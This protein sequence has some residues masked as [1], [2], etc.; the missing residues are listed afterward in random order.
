MEVIFLLVAVVTTLLS[1]YML[2]RTLF[3]HKELITAYKTSEFLGIFHLFLGLVV[4]MLLFV[5]LCA[6]N[7]TFFQLPYMILH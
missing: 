6:I 5:T 4:I 3:T 7:N 1:I 2:G